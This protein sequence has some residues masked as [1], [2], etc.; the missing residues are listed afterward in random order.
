MIFASIRAE[1]FKVSRRPSMWITIGLLL[2]VSV[3]L[4]YVLVYIVATHPPKGVN[5]RL[6]GTLSSL[7]LDLYPA[8]LVPKVLANMS[9]LYGIFALIA[10]VLVQGSEFGWGTVKTVYVQFPGRIAIAVGQLVTIALLVLIM[11]LGLFAVDAATA[12]VLATI[13]GQHITWPA[14]LDVIKG[15]AAA[16]LILYLMAMAGYGLA[17]VFRQS[18]LAIGLGLGYVLVIENLVFG[19]LVNLGDTFQHI[20]EWFPVA[21]AQYLQQAFGVLR[22]AAAGGEGPAAPPVDGTH[23]LTVLCLWLA[24]IVIASV[25]VVKLRDVN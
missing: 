2:A 25:A 20:R 9:G 18:A 12:S 6:G 22:A 11:A 4:E 15:V 23:A 19:L 14:A 24:A 10:G 16:W 17:T 8:A 5:L 1:W 7:R 21:N 13:D 3:S